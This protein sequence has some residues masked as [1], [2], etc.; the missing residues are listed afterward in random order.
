MAS[1]QSAD[2]SFEEEEEQKP[3]TSRINSMDAHNWT[4]S[5]PTRNILSGSQ[6]L[7]VNDKQQAIL[8]QEE[9]AIE[10]Q[11]DFEGSSSA[12]NVNAADVITAGQRY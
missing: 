9:D 11:E 2:V 7:E 12:G 10:E 6:D 5:S 4:G 1:A 3:M 8:V